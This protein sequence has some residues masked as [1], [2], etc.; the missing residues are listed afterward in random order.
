MK[1]FI[2]AWRNAKE[3]FTLIEL[4]VVIAIIGILA[5]ML[6]PAL[7][8][9]KD[10][11]K[12]KMAQTE[13]NSLVNAIQQY[14]SQY[15]RLPA[16]SLAVQAAAGEIATTGNSNDF[17]FG[18][19]SQG[20]PPSSGYVTNNGIPIQTHGEGGGKTG[21]TYYNYNSEVISILRD[22]NFWPEANSNA[23]PVALHVYNPQQTAFINGKNSG[24]TNSPGI[25]LDDVYRDPWGDPYI[26]TEDLGYDG[27]CFDYALNQMYQST[28]T[29]YATP[30][31]PLLVPGEAIVWSFGPAKTIHLNEPLSSTGLPFNRQ[32]IVTSFQ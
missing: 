14:Y 27:K 7:S 25:G 22:D 3:A 30:P 5:G 13:E 15:S 19:A 17:T 18:T 32:T 10:N 12:K 1:R 21:T 20:V 28:A 29:G 8:K 9:A 23:S 2:P 26:I 11:A 24:D 4:L 6:L 31:L 16:S